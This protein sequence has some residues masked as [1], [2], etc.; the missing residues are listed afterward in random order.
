[1]KTVV[2][3]LSLLLAAVS[4]VAQ[5]VEAWNL[6]GTVSA[7]TTATG[8]HNGTISLGSAISSGQYNGGTEYFGE[9]GWP[10]G[11]LDQNAYL[12]IPV[13]PNSGYFLVL[14][15]MTLTMRHSTTGTS[16]GSGPLTWSLRSSLDGYTSDL[17]TGTLTTSYQNY[18][19]NL[20]S[21]FQYTTGT[22]RFRVYGYNQVTTTGGSNRFVFDNISLSG[23][24]I[25]M[26]LALR[27]L[28]LT[29]KPVGSEIG[30]QWSAEGAD[31][32]TQYS[33][34]RSADGSQF[35]AIGETEDSVFTD[36]SAP[37]GSDSYYRVKAVTPDGESIYSN[38]ARI[39]GTATSTASIRSVVA[40]GSSLQALLHFAGA[41]ACQVSIWSRDGKAIYR[42]VLEVQRGD[43]SV[44]LAAGT[45]PH[46]IYVLTVS[47][48]GVNSSKLFAL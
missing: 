40:Q 24:S 48:D 38:V 13:A 32:G 12:Q 1:M 42:Q 45:W 30:L 33:I 23:S 19:I 20:P 31:A 11:A 8:V 43:Q 28:K 39:A 26:T 22:I 4:A 14:N 6:N 16:A 10:S 17:A 37:A 29:A 27:S 9:D 15:S 25:A 34:E 7:T 44:Q 46:G 5:T 41:G 47:A 36:G 3:A 35:S 21:A 2:M 18:T